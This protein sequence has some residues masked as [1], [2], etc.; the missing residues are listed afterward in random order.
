V[1]PA[2]SG[3]QSAAFIYDPADLW[4]RD[5][6]FDSILFNKLMKKMSK[7]NVYSYMDSKKHI[8]FNLIVLFLCLKLLI[9]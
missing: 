2:I 1:Y 9:E 8:F 7:I 4:V 3:A 5:I 6:N